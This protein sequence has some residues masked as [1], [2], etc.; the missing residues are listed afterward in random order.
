MKLSEIIR[1]LLSGILISFLVFFLQQG[2]GYDVFHCLCD[3]FFV[4]GVLLAGIGGLLFVSSKGVF[5]LAFYSVRSL[6]TIT[7]R[8][9]RS[10]S[11]SEY[12]ERKRDERRN[13]KPQLFTGL[14]FI[15]LSVVF[16]L[17]GGYIV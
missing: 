15:L 2:R 1:S 3:A 17:Y 12:I 13:W 7:F 4:S 14:I 11:P 16:L 9:E 5:D 6:F 8:K 10:E